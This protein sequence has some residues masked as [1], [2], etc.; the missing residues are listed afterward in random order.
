MRPGPDSQ[1][2]VFEPSQ[3]LLVMVMVV[4]VIPET[5]LCSLFGDSAV[6]TVE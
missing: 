6:V 5:V 3:N 1:A 2:S 4:V